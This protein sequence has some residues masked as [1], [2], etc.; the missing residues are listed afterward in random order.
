M[1]ICQGTA[2]V[3]QLNQRF[4]AFFHLFYE[5]RHIPGKAQ[6]FKKGQAS[7]TNSGKLAEQIRQGLPNKFG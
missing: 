7:R 1:N 2:D 5:R 3:S 6:S 4:P